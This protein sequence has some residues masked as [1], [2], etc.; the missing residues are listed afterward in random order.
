MLYGGRRV[1]TDRQVG[2]DGISREKSRVGGRVYQRD[3]AV[4]RL[5]AAPTMVATGRVMLRERPVDF[6][7]LSRA[8]WPNFRAGR[9]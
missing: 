8:D 2:Q 5:V 6:K 3:Q 7:T 9:H 1:G 4:G